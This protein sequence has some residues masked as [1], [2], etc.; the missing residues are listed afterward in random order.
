MNDECALLVGIQPSSGE[1]DL[2]TRWPFFLYFLIR[3]KNLY[4]YRNNFKEVR[5]WNM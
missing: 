3:I 1:A 2:T 5:L 4:L